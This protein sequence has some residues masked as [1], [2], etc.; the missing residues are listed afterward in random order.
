M[1]G[2]SEQSTTPRSVAEPPARRPRWSI[3]IPCYRSG[4]WLP[5]LVKEIAAHAGDRLEALELVLVDDASPDAETWPA[6]ERLAREQPFVRGLRLQFNVGQYRAL[7]A[8]L[9]ASRGDWVVTMDDDF[10]THPRELPRFF[11]AALAHPGM[12]A[13]IGRYPEKRH[14]AV[15]N[16]G[17]RLFARLQERLYDRP[18]DLETTSYRILSRPL[19]DTLV[20][21]RVIDPVFPS[22][23]LTNTRRLMN[24]DI[25]HHARAHG[26]SG[27]SFGRLV[28]IVLGQVFDGS[29]VPL[30]A[31]SLLGLAVSAGSIAFGAY[32]FFSWWRGTIQEPGFTTLVLLLTFLS[33]TILLSLGVMG[34]YVMRLVVQLSGTPRYV[35]RSSTD[36]RSPVELELGAPLPE[37]AP[38]ER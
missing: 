4:R 20:G 35:V 28:G 9:E 33:G 17:S 34:E 7:M 30:R 14:N 36:E 3:V 25:E 2:E 37:Q 1:V 11:E 18:A 21:S 16:A 15:R 12:D 19:V 5:E 26:A 38:E 10:Q 13:I 8:G 22:I 27:Y 31:V 6:I 29:A 24:I 32:S 23:I